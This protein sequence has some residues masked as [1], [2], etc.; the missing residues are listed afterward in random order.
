MD[1]ERIYWTVSRFI[2][3]AVAAG[4]FFGGWAY[5]VETYGWF[6]GGAFGW[7]PSAILAA[8][9]FFLTLALWPI[10]I[11]AALFYARIRH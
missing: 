5:A 7:F 3:G 6:L 2:A 4:V 10:A 8:F 11:L 9:A 1:V